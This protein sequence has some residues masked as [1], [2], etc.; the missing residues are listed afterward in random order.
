MQIELSQV[1]QFGALGVLALVLWGVALG[2]RLW[3]TQ[4]KELTERVVAVVSEN[5]KVIAEHTD[6]TQQNRDGIIEV[7]DNVRDLVMQLATRPCQAKELANKILEESKA[8]KPR[9]E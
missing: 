6:A 7:R 3:A 9:R 4:S 1:L 8:A 2:V 5:S